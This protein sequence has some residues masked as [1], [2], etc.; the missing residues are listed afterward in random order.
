M[1]KAMKKKV[2]QYTGIFEPADVKLV[3]MEGD[4]YVDPIDF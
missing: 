1:K 2:Y 3:Q 4:L